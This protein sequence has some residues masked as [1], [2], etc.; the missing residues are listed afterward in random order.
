MRN[1]DS[2]TRPG[3]GAGPGVS[4]GLD[5]VREVAV[6][7]KD[8]RFTAL[9]HHITLER[10]WKVFTELKRDA[11]PGADGLT[12]WQYEQDLRANL[13]DLHGRVQSGK[14]RA[15]PVRR[16][17]IPKPDGR[18]RPLGVGTDGSYCPS[19]RSVWG[20]SCFLVSR[21]C[22][23]K[24]MAAGTDIQGRGQRC[25]RGLVRRAAGLRCPELVMRVRQ[26]ASV[27]GVQGMHSLP[28]GLRRASSC[29][30]SI[31]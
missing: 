16:V 9:L 10:L 31:Q 1:T 29:P 18:M 24:S 5:R 30:V 15:K 3:R 11:A 12:W 6:R 13:E 23:G 22:Y 8:A 28:P 26:S 2:E 27:A 4:S 19:C 7:E 21:C 14:Y 17:L 20:F 25:W